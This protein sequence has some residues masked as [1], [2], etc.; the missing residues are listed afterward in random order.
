MSSA[1]MPEDFLT[2][3]RTDWE[4]DLA[5]E[6]EIADLAEVLQRGEREGLWQCL[7]LTGAVTE[8]RK[9]KSWI[10]FRVIRA[11]RLVPFRRRDG[12]GFVVAMIV[13]G[14]ALGAYMIGRW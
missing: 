2:L 8:P 12:I 11:A 5:E 1:E 10:A 7:N 6:V 13:I 9:R 4:D 14:I 3:T